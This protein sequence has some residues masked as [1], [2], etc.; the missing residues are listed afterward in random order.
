MRTKRTPNR[1]CLEA[2]SDPS[3]LNEFSTLALYGS[4]SP[5]DIQSDFHSL[6]D[7]SSAGENP[8][9]AGGINIY[10]YICVFVLVCD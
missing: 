4:A 5:S 8:I 2:S 7:G 10:I 3:Y 6:H 9:F 1:E